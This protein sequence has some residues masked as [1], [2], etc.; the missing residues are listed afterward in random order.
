[1]KISLS[2]GFLILLICSCGNRN[3]ANV[4]EFEIY[5][6]SQYCGG[7]APS[8]EVLA[9]LKE[10]KPSNDTLYIRRNFEDSDGIPLILKNGKGKLTGL[11]EGGY[12][13]YR[14]PK[15]KIEMLE[16][17]P[18]PDAGCLM[19]YYNNPSFSFTIEPETNIV[20]DTFILECNPCVPPAE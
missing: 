18:D 5:T 8:D 1:M 12:F 3:Q 14:F 13:V 19:S 10:P 15:S 4:I 16:M 6:T 17:S 9:D 2:A 20:K 11:T 7:A